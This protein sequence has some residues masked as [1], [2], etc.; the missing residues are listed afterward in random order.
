M[1]KVLILGA[2]G[3]LGQ[4]LVVEFQ[5][6]GYEKVIGWDHEDG[7]ITDENIFIK[8]A[9]LKPEI[10]INAT[11]Y[12]A[13]DKAETDEAEL[14]H[15]IN[16]EAPKKLA[17]IAKKIGAVFV[18]YSTDYV[19][20]GENKEGYKEEDKTS[21]ISEYGRSKEAG[22]RE[23]VAAGGKYYIIRLSRLFGQPGK[24]ASSKKSFVNIMLGKIGEPVVK[25]VN[26]E[27]D[28]PTYA[29]D[30]AAFTR[31]IIEKNM[32]F[33]IYHGANRGVCTW[34]EF[35]VE[36]FKIKQ[37]AVNLQP[38]PASEFPRPARRPAH[39]ELLN[40]KMPPQ[41]PWQKALKEYLVG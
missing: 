37:A 7:D 21:P 39:S 20:G 38:V 29:P 9:A 12:N 1:K 6:N 40:T 22:E 25:V 17:E 15:K 24:S 33:G 11:G 3:T 34:Y 13:V 30:L 2:K 27:M 18:N 8:I 26:E 10:I 4:G 19:F 5:R 14:A 16:A 32:P 35:A 31:A 41:R 23:V 28:S 36:I